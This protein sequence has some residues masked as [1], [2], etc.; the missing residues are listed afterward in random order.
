MP[1]SFLPGSQERNVD[2]K[3]AREPPGSPG[4]PRYA[5]HVAGELDDLEAWAAEARAREAAESRVRERW[6]RTQAEEGAEF[7]A[8]LAGM[9]ERAGAV[10]VT[11]SAGHRLSGR[12]T[13]VGED[14]VALA[15]AGDR[16]TLVALGALA[17]V[18]AAP[19]RRGSEPAMAER[20]G[21]SDRTDAASLMD[22]LAQAVVNRPRVAVQTGAAAVSGEL[23]AVGIDVLALETAGEPPSLVYVPLRSV[24]EISFLDSG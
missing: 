14:F 3:V 1:E 11:T 15:V 24:Y 10:T 6:L 16:R 22:V 2:Q 19:G 7:A 21:T 23:R 20:D 18:Q 17:C 9:V 5:A 13:A 12:L 4:T 8:V